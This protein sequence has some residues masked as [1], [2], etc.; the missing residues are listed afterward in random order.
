MEDLED[1]I[2]KQIDQAYFILVESNM[3]G[4]FEAILAKHKEGLDVED[5]IS[6]GV[7]LGF[8]INNQYHI[9]NIG[10]MVKSETME[11]EIEDYMNYVFSLVNRTR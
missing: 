3:I 6:L 8:V 9:N 5:A 4:M 7:L 2:K 11:M 1:N 10:R